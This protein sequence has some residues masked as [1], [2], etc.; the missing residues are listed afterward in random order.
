[1]DMEN[2]SLS[3]QQ[4]TPASFD[5]RLRQC[6][7]HSGS[8]LCVGLDPRSALANGSG[9]PL[10][11][12][13]RR[14]I[15][16]T[17]RYVVAYKANSAFFEASGVAGL[18]D[19]AKVMAYRPDNCI[20]ILDA[21]RGDLGSTAVAYAQAA[22]RVQHAD[23]V[24][25]N[26]YLGHDAVAPFLG[27]PAHGAFILCHTSNPGAQDF[28]SLN[29]GGRPLYMEVAR[30]ALGWNALG[31]VGLVVGATYPKALAAVRELAPDI[32]FLV[33]GIGAQG[34]DLEAALAAGLDG[35][36]MGLV[37]NSSRDII[38]AA[39]PGTAAQRLRDSINTIR[40]RRRP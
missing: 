3:E 20:M 40:E 1:M 7:E 39:E 31:N 26:P 34:G 19:L 11:D 27:D 6:I 28:Q 4:L 37:V 25:V 10:V 32:P 36:G 2:L 12:F 33:P 9:E 15:D 8:L 24:T 5:Q 16:A 17:A 18:S 22:F 35:R 13:C 21:K 23:A 30:Q 29:V 14:V 38:Y